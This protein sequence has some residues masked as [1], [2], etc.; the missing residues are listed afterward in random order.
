MIRCRSVLPCN[1]IMTRPRVPP[2]L[3]DAPSQPHVA[4]RSPLTQLHDRTAAAH[5]A[6]L[7]ELQEAKAKGAFEALSA[8]RGTQ[9][10]GG[11]ATACV[12]VIRATK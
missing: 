2:G 4:Q 5:G 8:V 10:M 12:H 7:R 1:R 11:S 3:C 9:L 6:G